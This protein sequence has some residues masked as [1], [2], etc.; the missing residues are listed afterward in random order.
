ME[1]LAVRFSAHDGDPFAELTYQTQ[2]TGSPV[3]DGS[4]AFFDCELTEE[5][6]VGTHTIFVGTVVACGTGTGAPLGYYGGSFR[7]FN[8]PPS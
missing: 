7:D 8:L 4:L 6:S 1:Q 2:A 3:L 5:H